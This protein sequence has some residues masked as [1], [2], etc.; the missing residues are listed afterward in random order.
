MSFPKALSFWK[1]RYSAAQLVGAT[2]ISGDVLTNYLS[3][4]DL[5]LCSE[6][7]GRGRARQFCL[8]DVYL[9]A[10]M[11]RL[12]HLT[13]KAKWSA[14]ALNSFLFSEVDG[15]SFVA[16]KQN[17]APPNDQDDERYA[18][19]LAAKFCIDIGRAPEP[20]WYRESLNPWF[21]FAESSNIA[22]DTPFISAEQLKT[23]DID[24][25][26][27]GGDRQLHSLH[28]GVFLNTTRLFWRIDIR[29]ARLGRAP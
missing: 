27:V 14:L 10:L 16:H 20:F 4:T 26:C 15:Q 29:L 5:R 21:F 25:Q 24:A 1:K 3:K 7:S 12:T 2:E 28:E 6:S 8:I 19:Q 11:A 18:D 23:I 9:V 17:R 13:G 22:S